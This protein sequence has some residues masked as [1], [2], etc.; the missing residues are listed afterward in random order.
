MNRHHA[1]NHSR[2]ASRPRGIAGLRPQGRSGARQAPCPPS[3]AAHCIPSIPSLVRKYPRRRHPGI[4]TS[5]RP[6][7][8]HHRKTCKRNMRRHDRHQAAAA[9]ALA[10]GGDRGLRASE[11]QAKQAPRGCSSMVEQQLPKLTTRVRFP[12]PAPPP[13]ARHQP[14]R[15]HRRIRRVPG[16]ALLSRACFLHRVSWVFSEPPHMAA[17]RI[18]H[19]H[20]RAAARRRPAARAPAHPSAPRRFPAFLRPFRRR[21]RRRVPFH[22]PAPSRSRRVIG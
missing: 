15:R 14:A 5:S 10:Q 6:G 11:R 12:S 1:A 3:R 22:S 21:P 19:R 4:P 8:E 16:L 20:P 2:N 18:S 17:T 9:G 7:Q 13:A